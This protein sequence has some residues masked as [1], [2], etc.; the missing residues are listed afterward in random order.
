MRSLPHGS[1]PFSAISPVSSMGLVMPLIVISPASVIWP[2]EPTSVAVEW[3]LICG[4]LV[5]VEELGALEVAVA[6]GVAGVDGGD[7]DGAR[8][9]GGVTAGVDRALERAEAAADGGDAHVPDLEA[10]VG[11]A[12][13]DGVGAGRDLLK[14]G[15]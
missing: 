1:W 2:S 5:G 10:D 9:D 6:V 7:V 12:G 3:K 15:C 14:R 11:V 8:E 4:L 13:V